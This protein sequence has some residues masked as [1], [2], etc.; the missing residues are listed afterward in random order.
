MDRRA[1][2][3][4]L[5]DGAEKYQAAAELVAAHLRHLLWRIRLLDPM[6]VP[7][8]VSARAKTLKSALRKLKRHPRSGSIR[9]RRAI[10][11]CLDDLAGVRVVCDYLSD[12]E[13]IRGYLHEHPAFKVIHS[14]TK[15]YIVKPN[16]GYRG[17]HLVVRIVTS[18]G[19]IKCE[20]QVRTTLQHA[21]AEKTHDLIYKLGKT[22]LERIPRQIRGLV[23]D[24]SNM[25]YDIDVSSLKIFRLIKKKGEKK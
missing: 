22:D 24:Q 23:E 3:K 1:L 25:L 14:K 20:V 15:D 8:R 12:V 10:E 19:W 18:F 2:R 13:A 5:E 4:L 6:V 16:K 7:T 11:A 17:I 21:W 9:T